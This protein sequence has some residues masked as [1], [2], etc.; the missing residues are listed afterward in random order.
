MHRA[1]FDAFAFKAFHNQVMQG[2]EGIFGETISAQSILVGHHYQFIIEL[3]G[4][5]AHVFE[6]VRV[7]GEFVK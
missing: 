3:T 5:A 7:K 2:P 6:H 1:E 4:Y